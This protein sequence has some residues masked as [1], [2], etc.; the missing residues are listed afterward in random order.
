MF[1]GSC[2]GPFCVFQGPRTSG[3]MLVGAGV[4]GHAPLRPHQTGAR[5][6][7]R[8]SAGVKQGQAEGTAPGVFLMSGLRV[9]AIELL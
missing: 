2:F 8:A 1:G 9:V 7:A 6:D 5:S 4:A 3:S